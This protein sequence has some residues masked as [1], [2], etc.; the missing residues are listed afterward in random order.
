M[1]YN[2]YNSEKY[3]KKQSLL[4]KAAWKRGVFDFIKKKEER[5]CKR[6]ECGRIF[7]VRPSDHKVYCSQTCA[8]I[9]NNTGV[10]RWGRAPNN[11][12]FCGSKTER[13]GYKYCSIRCQSDYQ[14][15]SYIKRWQ[16]G[17]VSGLST[18]GTVTRHIKRYLREKYKNK[19]SLCGWSQINPITG[20]VPLVA[21]H[22]DGNWRNNVEENLRLLCPNCDSLTSTF[23]GLNKGNGRKNR[24]PS[25]RTVAGKALAATTRIDKSSII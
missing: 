24:A 4:V 18:L 3:R 12:L 13:F 6:K 5:I 1:S 8:A 7:I 21:D 25:K 19:C 23:C 9:I 10:R 11:C 2:F 20:S 22:I 16:T 14:F 17:K 15:F